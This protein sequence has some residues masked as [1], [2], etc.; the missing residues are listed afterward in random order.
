MKEETKNILKG[1]TLGILLTLS[2]T[3]LAAWTEPTAPPPGANVEAP[4]NV[5]NNSQAKGGN[6]TLNT[7]NIKEYGLIV[8]YGKLLISNT[9]PPQ[10]NNPNELYV[11]GETGSDKFCN[12]LGTK[13]FTVDQLCAKAPGSWNLC[14]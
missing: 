2:G 6:L 1:V 7:N 10:P 8:Q 3:V 5:S 14:P 4:I 12:T 11:K 13:C 9:A